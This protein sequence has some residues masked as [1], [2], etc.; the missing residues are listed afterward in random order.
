MIYVAAQWYNSDP[1]QGAIY[2]WRLSFHWALEGPVVYRDG[3]VQ[4][5]RERPR[6][7]IVGYYGIGRIVF[8]LPLWRTRRYCEHGFRT[9]GWWHRCDYVTAANPDGLVPDREL[10]PADYD[11]DG[12][13]YLDRTCFCDLKPDYSICS[14]HPDED[15]E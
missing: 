9:S 6:R 7:K 1:R 8:Y 4:T 12:V 3:R 2:V 5:L 14:M 15:G 13:H 11:E 10:N